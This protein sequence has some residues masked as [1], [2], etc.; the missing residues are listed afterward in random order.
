MSAG[1]KCGKGADTHVHNK[2]GMGKFMG[3]WCGFSEGVYGNAA[4]ED[5]TGS[6][7][8]EI[9]SDPCRHWL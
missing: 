3:K 6:G 4:E 7:P 8:A 2:R 5:R 1:K 9:Y